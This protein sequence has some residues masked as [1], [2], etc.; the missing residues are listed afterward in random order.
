MNKKY[1][2]M[3]VFDL[4]RPIRMGVKFSSYCISFREKKE[5]LKILE[6][7]K[8][9]RMEVWSETAEQQNTADI[10]LT[11]DFSLEK[12][13]FLLTITHTHTHTYI[14]TIL[15]AQCFVQIKFILQKLTFYDFSICSYVD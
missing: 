3:F 14:Y 1:L 9:R 12:T 5:K 6:S 2:T 7:A 8:V 11:A 10:A 13:G 15:L 4:L